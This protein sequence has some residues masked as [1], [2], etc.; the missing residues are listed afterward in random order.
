[1]TD[2]Q[3]LVALALAGR[4]STAALVA[5]Y[6][7]LHREYYQSNRPDGECY[8]PE[9]RPVVETIGSAVEAFS[10]L[11]RMTGFDALIQG[12]AAADDPAPRVV[13]GMSDAEVTVAL[14]QITEGRG[15]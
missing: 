5:T 1:M 4:N 9:V 3:K 11:E 6:A 12:P 14:D 10:E 15:R 13:T 8:P 7:F 2:T